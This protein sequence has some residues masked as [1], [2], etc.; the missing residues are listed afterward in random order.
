[1]TLLFYYF[2]I[3]FFFINILHKFYIIIHINF[4]SIIRIF[5]LSKTHHNVITC[6]YQE[7]EQY[8]LYSYCLNR[9][10]INLVTVN[11]FIYFKDYH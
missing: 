2:I 6:I 4:K 8:C 10:N 3:L 11:S 5:L 7:Q 9:H 1:M